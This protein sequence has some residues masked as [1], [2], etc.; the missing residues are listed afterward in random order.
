MVMDARGDGVR[1]RDW[2][3]SRMSDMRSTQRRFLIAFRS[4]AGRD[5]TVW[6]GT[7]DNGAWRFWNP[8][9]VYCDTRYCSI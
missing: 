8:D 4:T 9:I 5:G 1:F 6:F 3:R 7:R 2:L